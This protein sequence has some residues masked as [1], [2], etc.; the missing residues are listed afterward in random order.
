M[1]PLGAVFL[2]IGVGFLVALIRGPRAVQADA[3]TAAQFPD[4]PW[5]WR[6][7]AGDRP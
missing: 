4:A 7:S 5:K 2:L 6:A 3:K 1:L